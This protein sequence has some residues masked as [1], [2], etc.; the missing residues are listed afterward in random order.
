MF[1]LFAEK[2]GSASRLP[3]EHDVNPFYFYPYTHNGAAVSIV[4]PTPIQY[5]YP[6]LHS[7]IKYL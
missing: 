4:T 1:V 5:C 3:T 7:S 2:N 6:L